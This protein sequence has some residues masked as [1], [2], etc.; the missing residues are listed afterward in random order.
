[1]VSG[2]EDLGSADRYL[3][4]RG[5]G[6]AVEL[7]EAAAARREGCGVEVVREEEGVCGGAGRGGRGATEGVGA[8]PGAEAPG[9]A[10]RRFCAAT[11]TVLALVAGGFFFLAVFHLRSSACAPS[12]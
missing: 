1:M 8:E 3:K 11:G 12:T 4:V 9:A 6:V 5:V 10:V 7:R 2:G